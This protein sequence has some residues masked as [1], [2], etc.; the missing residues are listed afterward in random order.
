M[1]SPPSMR[2]ISP[3]SD[4]FCAP[5]QRRHAANSAKIIVRL[6]GG[7]AFA[8]ISLVWSQR[9][10]TLIFACG[11]YL[12]ITLPCH[13]SR[14]EP[15]RSDAPAKSVPEHLATSRR[16]RDVVRRRRGAHPRRRQLLP[17]CCQHRSVVT[18]KTWRLFARASGEVLVKSEDTRAR[19][20]R[21]AALSSSSRAA[22]LSH[23]CSSG[24]G[25]GA[26]RATSHSA[27]GSDFPAWLVC[28]IP[29]RVW[30]EIFRRRAVSWI[31]R[32]H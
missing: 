16:G 11:K 8:R 27:P 32:P 12:D 18:N 7:V 6:R 23:G 25:G 5:G 19:V 29:L 31:L 3:G 2:G 20:P 28:T 24:A 9:A 17:C 13:D 4:L 21:D 30:A 26:V 10:G 15:V 14:D 22:C 1:I